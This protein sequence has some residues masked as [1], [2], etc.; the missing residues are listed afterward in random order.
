MPAAEFAGVRVVGLDALRRDLRRLDKR[1]PGEVL[2]RANKAAGEIVAGEARRRAPAGEHQGGGTVVPI[3][4]SIRAGQQARRAVVSMGGGRTPHAEVT[5]FGGTIPRRGVDP[6]VSATVRA[7]HQSYARH[8]LSVTHVEQRAF[9]YPAIY[10]KSDE[11]VARYEQLVA[12][13]LG[14]AF[15]D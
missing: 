7:R 2:G 6:T 3:A 11:V 9:L 12:D 13:A 1:L 8:G 4:S 10:A 14:D 5:E 15:T